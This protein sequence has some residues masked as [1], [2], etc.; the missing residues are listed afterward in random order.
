MTERK[1]NRKGQSEGGL[2]VP[3]EVLTSEGQTVDTSGDIWE[4][5]VRAESASTLKLNLASAL[6]P[7]A[8][9]FT[10][11]SRKLVRLYLAERLRTVKASTVRG[12][13]YAFRKFV[14]WWVENKSRTLKW[15]EVSE[16]DWRAFL[17]YC[18][19]STSRKGGIFTAL[20]SFYS[21]GAFQKELPDFDRDIA[22][23][24]SIV[25]APGNKKGEA[26]RALDSHRGPLDD[27]EI[28]L[29]HNALDERAGTVEE[30]VVV[31][32]FLE[33]GIRPLAVTLI[34]GKHFS[35]HDVPVAE[36]GKED[37]KTLYQLEVP[38]LKDRGADITKWYT[39]PLSNDLGQGLERVSQSD[40]DLLLAWLADYQSPEKKIG[41]YLKSWVAEAGLISPRTGEILNL[42]PRRFR[43]TLATDMAV[44]G[45]SKAQIAQALGHNDL[46]NVDVYMDASAVILDRME[47]EDAFDFQDEV[48]ELFMGKVGDPDDEDVSEQRI[49]GAAPQVGG[50][51][52]TT[53]HIG[54]C[55]KQSPCSLSPPLSCYTC[56]KFV[57]FEDAPHED[58][59]DELEHWI[60]S[61]PEGV[62]RRIPQQH[63]TTLKAIRQLLQQ[64]GDE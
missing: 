5:P 44:Q 20:R 57:A 17:D 54:A 3:S 12:D 50:L 16:S 6:Q 10:S 1:N 56:K 39:R 2:E 21:W 23:S 8:E 37:R 62:D 63:V 26:V 40:E 11:R 58:I 38:K 45:A 22:S 60:K 31:R 36:K 27:D 25:R 33:L 34:R 53:G 52:G 47:E 59:K 41:D 43:R 32:L 55:Q 49:P 35:R 46:Q 7:G 14:E 9:Q 4:L 64:L 61:S 51:K 48:V 15:D 13:L 24:I 29:I 42:F 19:K 28:K 18:V 30:R